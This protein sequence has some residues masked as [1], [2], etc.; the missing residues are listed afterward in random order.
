MILKKS[1]FFL[2]ITLFFLSISSDIQ[3]KVIRNK[4]YDIE[5]YV[6]LKKHSSFENNKMYY[7]YK[8]GEI[9]KSMTNAGGLLL[10][11]D[12]MK[13]FRSNQLAE[14]GQFDYG[15]KDGTWKSWYTD[16]NI[17]TSIQ[18]KHGHKHGDYITYDSLSNKQESGAYK[19]NIKIGRWVNHKTNDTIY[20][21]KGD[22]IE[23]SKIKKESFFKRIMK[24]FKKKDSTDIKAKKKTKKTNS[25]KKNKD[26]FFKRLFKKK[27]KS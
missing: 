7:W 20:Y 9:H 11:S 25:K 21:K 12:Y 17:K 4:D 27:E 1:L 19:H 16:G 10:H 14:K 3:K 13:Y 2:F 18:W 23:D 22:V 26:S 8:S 6:S 5:L 24:P 15:L